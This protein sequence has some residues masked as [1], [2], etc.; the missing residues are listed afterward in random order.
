ML[1]NSKKYQIF[2][3][4]NT[5]VL[6]T[7]SVLCI[8]P[9]IHIL[10][11]SFSGKEVASANL[12]NLIPIDFTLD[13]YKETFLNDNFLRSIG[14]ST[15]RTILGTLIFLILT[16]LTAYPLS[17]NP[18]AFKGRSI[19]I[20]FFVF[21]MLFTGGLIPSYILIMNL[22][23]K[24]S[25]WALI[26]P[27]A[28]EVWSIIML[29]NFFRGIPKELEEAALIDGAGE[30][31]TMVKIYLPLSPPALATLALF[32]MVT[33]WN[34]WFDGMIYNT[35]A[36]HYPLATLL[37]TIIVQQD[38]SKISMNPE[39]LANISQRTVKSAQIFIGSLPILMV[40]P[41]LQKYFVKG[42]VLGAVKE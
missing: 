9:L 3:V 42:I 19:Y 27:G 25:I 29:L 26:L 12:V 39:D 10:A 15:Y 17:K 5:I 11:V 40:Y 14:I 8:L 37:Q 31:V 41:F 4:F 6:S 21:T 30:F 1:Y 22:G 32:T 34:S 38:F 33:H 24:N 23:L 2:S 28:V 7:L 35:D 18:S 16:A 36:K 20:W 13:A